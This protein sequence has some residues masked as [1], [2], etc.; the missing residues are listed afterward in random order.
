[1]FSFT[2]KVLCIH[3][4]SFSQIKYNKK[5]DLLFLSNNRFIEG[6]NCVQFAAIGSLF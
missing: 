6:L 4:L 2:K 1:M 3:S 5:E